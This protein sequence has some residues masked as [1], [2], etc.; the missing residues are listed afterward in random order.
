[1][2]T[3]SLVLGWVAEAMVTGPLLLGQS[4][5]FLRL[6]RHEK[7]KVELLF[8][9]FQNF[10]TA[11]LAYL[12][13]GLFSFLWCLPAVLGILAILVN[14]LPRIYYSRLFLSIAEGDPCIDERQAALHYDPAP[15]FFY[16]L[17]RLLPLIFLSSLLLII[18]GIIAFLSY[19][20][21]FFIIADNPSIC[22]WQ[23]MRKSRKMMRGYK[24]KLF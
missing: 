1:M 15:N 11:S 18:L 24:W 2:V 23:A 20:M 14:S 9:G 22:S 6:A 7:A 4:L 21:T 8:Q 10:F 17:E 3:H 16:G 5:L 19:S 12:L 13:V